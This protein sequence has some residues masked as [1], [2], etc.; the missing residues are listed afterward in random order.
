MFELI[1]IERRLERA[2]QMEDDV[3]QRLWRPANLA[4]VLALLVAAIISGGPGATRAAADGGPPSGYI[5]PEERAGAQK[6][7]AALAAWLARSPALLFDYAEVTMSLWSE[8]QSFEARN[9]CG[10]GSV[11]AVV[12]QWRGNAYVD[13]YSDPRNGLGPDAYMAHLARTAPGDYGMIVNQETS[14]GNYLRVVNAETLSSFYVGENPGTQS[15]YNDILSFDIFGSRHP[16]APVANS[17]FLVGWGTTSVA[18]FVTVK[19]YWVSGDT[20]TYGDTASFVQ[21][22]SDLTIGWHVVSLTAFYT[23]AVQPIAPPV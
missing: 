1:E 13:N 2:R 6:K 7:D 11:T 8:P 22:G 9:W 10:P 19:Q 3:T 4:F 21:S 23:Q 14:L 20:T 5:S 17:A 18:H 15:R 16:L 12:G